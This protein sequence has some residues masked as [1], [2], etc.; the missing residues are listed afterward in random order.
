MQK[1]PWLVP[2]L[3]TLMLPA[4]ACN[5]GGSDRDENPTVTEVEVTPTTAID[6]RVD[7]VSLVGT[8]GSVTGTG[9]MR[10]ERRGTT[11]PLSDLYADEVSGVD[12]TF[13]GAQLVKPLTVIFDAPPGARPDEAVPVVVHQKAEGE[14]EM[15]P[16]EVNAAGQ[17]L[18]RTRSFSFRAPAWLDPRKLIVSIFDSASDALIGRTDPDT[19]DTSK[20]SWATMTKKTTLVHPCLL[21][22]TAKSGAERAEV[23]VKSNRRFFTKVAIPGDP[24]YV[25][26]EQSDGLFLRLAADLEGLVGPGERVLAP[27]K[28]L[29]AG[30]LRPTEDLSL[31]VVTYLDHWTAALSI[32]S[33]VLSAI[34]IEDRD[35]LAAAWA[36]KNCGSDVPADLKD[37]DGWAHFTVCVFGDTLAELANPVKAISAAAS[38]YDGDPYE[39]AAEEQLEKVGK[40]LRLLAKAVKVIGAAAFVRDVYNQIPDAFS[41]MGSDRTGDIELTLEAAEQPEAV[42]DCGKALAAAVTREFPGFGKLAVDRCEDGWAYLGSAEGMGDTEMV[43]QFVAGSWQWYAGMPTNLCPADVV[44]DGGPDWVIELFAYRDYACG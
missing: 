35:G 10:V 42:A 39:K 2:L 19:C 18:L 40:R 17:F 1:K 30:Y 21:A 23:K 9:T 15:V 44:A 33:S 11:T 20:P 28:R 31:R 24:Q 38:L 34:D 36:L 29:S 12:V 6:V 41:Q 7:G 3:V 14:W 22:N 37:A 32:V 13:E 4:V 8:P 27:Q 5:G 25:W 43:W 16:A 26:A